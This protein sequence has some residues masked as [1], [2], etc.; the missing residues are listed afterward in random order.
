MLFCYLDESGDEQPLRTATDPP[1]LVLGGLV[2]DHER[3][4]G[5]TYDFLQLKKTFRPQLRVPGVQLSD[6]IRHEVKGSD[7]R[8]N[9]REGSRNQRRA[10][11]G[12]LDKLVGLLE[13]AN[14][15]IVGQ[16][17][18]KGAERLSTWVYPTTVAG[19][20]TDFE[21][22]LRA[23]D[24]G[25]CMVLD[26]RTKVKNAPSVHR[27]TTER[28]KTG[29]DPY[30][31]LT[32]SPVFGHSDAHVPLQ[33][34]DLLVSGLLF[35]MA[36]SVYANSL[37]HNVHLSDGYAIL[38]DRFGTRLRLLEH[39]YTRTG[40]GHGGGIRVRDG[41]NGQASIAL[42]RETPFDVERAARLRR[43]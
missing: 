13:G 43:D 35:P 1:V 4:R 14:S 12:F 2:V 23:A 7:L 8:R 34:A 25:G 31:H 17:H 28:F 3:A 18:V 39:R 30:P 36:C 20:A 10:V 19:I 22:Q 24:T 41:L 40:G 6:V 27:M 26:S 21:A 42:F 38:R 9:L 11:L 32:E 29:G 37:I 16:I 15:K 33:I 5:L